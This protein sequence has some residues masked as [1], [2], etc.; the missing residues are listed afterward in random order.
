M[1]VPKYTPEREALIQKAVEEVVALNP[2]IGAPSTPYT[3]EEYAE[4]LAE[5]DRYW[6]R[7]NEEIAKYLDEHPTNSDYYASD[8]V[9]DD[10]GE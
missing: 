1:A 4:L 2:N 9:N 8:A 7:Y 3:D 5:W 10:R 6:D